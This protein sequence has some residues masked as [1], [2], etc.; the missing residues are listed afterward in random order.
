MKKLTEF[1]SD[2]LLPLTLSFTATDIDEHP[3]TQK[4]EVEQT[5]K[6][7]EDAQSETPIVKAMKNALKEELCAWYGYIMIKEWL[8]GQDR[9]CISEFYEE[10]AKDE[11]E[12]HAY[13][14]MKRL[15]QLGADI[16]DI[17]DTP[18]SML[19]ATHPYLV[20]I[21]NGQNIDIKGSLEMNIQNELGA[22]ETYK[23]LVAMTDDVDPTSNS[24]LKEILADEEEHLQELKD[25]LADIE[26]TA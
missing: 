22:I 15:N 8:T 18:A 5:K 16:K 11:L 21:W 7:P 6:E 2:K 12:D 3:T 19:T 9:V 14:L 10:T 13:W 17:T 20:P 26:T 24:K 25:F 4:P 1:I 23:A